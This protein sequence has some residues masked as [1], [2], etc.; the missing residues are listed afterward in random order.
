VSPDGREQI[1]L[2]GD[3][4]YAATSSVERMYVGRSTLEGQQRWIGAKIG[5]SSESALATLRP[6]LNEAV[7]RKAIERRWTPVDDLIRGRTGIVTFQSIEQPNTME[8]VAHQIRVKFEDGAIVEVGLPDAG[9]LGITPMGADGVVGQEYGSRIG[10]V[11]ATLRREFAE[12]EGRRTAIVEQIRSRIASGIEPFNG[13]EDALDVHEALRRLGFNAGNPR[14][15]QNGGVSVT[16]KNRRNGA[17]IVARFGPR[18]SAVA[19]DRYQPL[20]GRTVAARSRVEV[21]SMIGERQR[22]HGRMPATEREFV[23]DALGRSDELSARLTGGPI[24]VESSTS[25]RSPMRA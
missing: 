23:A 24:P 8:V 21:G 3:Q 17:K 14:N 11:T 12:R 4:Q 22:V 13:T 15:L 19:E 5:T 10:A 6:G 1:T 20:T 16:F 7:V 9:D 2:H 25:S 18:S